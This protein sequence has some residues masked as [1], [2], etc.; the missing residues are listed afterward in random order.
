MKNILIT[1][2]FILCIMIWTSSCK[3]DFLDT[4]PSTEFSGDDIW[5]DPNLIEAFVN[6]IYLNVDNP[7]NGGDG[8]LKGE[9][10]DEMHD[11]WFSFFEFN[12]S[13]ITPDNLASWP[14]E[15]WDKLYKNIRS[16]NIYFSKINGA[17]IDDAQLK[18]RMTGEVHFLR[19]YLYHQ[20]VSLYGGV[21]IVKKAYG[22]NDVFAV[23]RDSYSDCI[24][25]ISKECD[26]AA[27]LLPLVQSGS[28]QGRVT[29]GAALALK[30]RALLY[31]ASDLHNK[32][33]FSGFAQQELIRYTDGNQAARW[34]AAKDAAKAVIDLGIYRLYK[35]DPAPG[36]SIAQNFANIFISNGTEEDI[37][38]RYFKTTSLNGSPDLNSLSLVSGPNGYHLYGQDTPSGEMADHFEMSDGS[39]FSWSD[40]SKAY[41]PYKNRDPRFY[42]S[43]LYEG[44]KFKP[45][46]SDITNLDPVGVIQVGTWQRWN[47][48]SNSMEEIYGLDS[49]KGPVENFNGG[50]TGYYLRKFIDPAING[51]F[52]TNGTPWRYMRYAEVLLNYAE[53]CIE[54]NEESEARS[55]LNQIRKRAGMPNITDSGN[56]LR[57]RYRNERRVE[58]AF[59]EHRFYDVRRWLIA[60]EAYQQFSGVSVV[61]KLNA[62]HT[63]ATIPTIT[64]IVVQKSAWLDKAYLFP[65]SR[66]EMNKNALLVQNPNY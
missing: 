26:S 44:V 3:K 24:N 43:I 33:V 31:A 35:A 62:D 12:N 21:P 29:K 19:A 42:A 61:Y 15:N 4:K 57:N 37:W 25:F 63:T 32:P 53:A 7:A 66:D 52:S 51:Q 47:V 16:C 56:A 9:F 55:A 28:N 64:P 10:V 34:R 48:S 1:C 13:L 22:L 30:A 45:R 8:L 11:Q 39:P 17:K 40:P 27:L 50:Y 65:V 36:D 60:P 5:N 2:S 23:K 38:V 58:L 20:L 54:L 46:P 41:Q 18:D 49:R 14:H 59:E 6:G